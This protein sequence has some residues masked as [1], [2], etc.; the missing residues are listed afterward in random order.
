MLISKTL[1]DG[2]ACYEMMTTQGSVT[3]LRLGSMTRNSP[4][5]LPGGGDV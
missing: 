3:E 5:G 2:E 1:S 4:R